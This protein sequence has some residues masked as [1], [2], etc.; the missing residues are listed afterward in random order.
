[1]HLARAS[2]DLTLTFAELGKVYGEIFS[3]KMGLKS[4]G[5]WVR[6]HDNWTRNLD[7]DY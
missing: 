4:T 6:C 2:D 3:I 7:G 1:M 5:E